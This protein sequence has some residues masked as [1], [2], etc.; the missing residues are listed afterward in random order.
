M[1]KGWCGSIHGVT[2]VMYMDAIH[3][4]SGRP[5]FI[6]HY[7]PY[8]DL[9]ERFFMTLQ[10]FD[11]LFPEDKRK[12][13]VFII[14]RGIY[15]IEVFKRFTDVG[16]YLITWEKNYQNNGWIDGGKTVDFRKFRTRNNAH[17]LREYSF[18]CQES[19]WSKM[20]G[21]RRFI[22]RAKNP[23]GRLIQLSVLCSD[24]EIDMAEAVWLIFNR[25]LQ[26]NDFKYLN[27]HFG[28]DQLTAYGIKDFEQDDFTDKDVDTTEY[29]KLKSS[30]RA[31][32]N[33]WA[34][35]LL[36]KE[37]KQAEIDALTQQLAVLEGDKTT[38]TQKR[39]E[40]LRENSQI[41]PKPKALKD[42]D[43]LLRAL[44][45]ASKKLSKKVI[46]ADN[47]LVEF[48]TVIDLSVQRCEEIDIQLTTVLRKSSKLEFL[49]E[50]HFKRH[51]TR[52]KGLL[53]ALRV[54]ASNMFAALM[55]DFRPLYANHRND[56][57]MLRQLTRADG[58]IETQNGRTVVSLWLKGS[59]Q[60]KQ[61]EAFDKFLNLLSHKINKHFGNDFT[62]LHI[63]ILDESPPH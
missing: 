27:A 16:D 25:W 61:L 36:K 33:T 50:N 31:E 62:P 1:M 4:R 11:R 54:T 52:A 17:D 58:F 48:N 53:D 5:C 9:R 29:K 39:S 14:D 42:C 18:S 2:K 30:L 6:Q 20:S 22:V 51:D 15:G 63:R 26:E 28:L 32:E 24:P 23:N 13:R 43:K 35:T 40:I 10:G 57:A 8:Y 3:T 21:M 44:A 37:K 45:T 41:K 60:K 47:K 49:N 12:G 55:S 34:K 56:H 46:A 59:Y 7:T 19:E 38:Q